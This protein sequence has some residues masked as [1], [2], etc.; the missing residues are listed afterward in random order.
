MPGRDKTLMR[1][2]ECINRTIAAA[3]KPG[4]KRSSAP[5]SA[6]VAKKVAVSLTRRA[7]VAWPSVPVSAIGRAEYLLRKVAITAPR[8]RKGDSFAVELRRSAE[9]RGGQEGVSR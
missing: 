3:L 4:P 6:V 9:R 7:A 2:I 1:T 5:G 8:I